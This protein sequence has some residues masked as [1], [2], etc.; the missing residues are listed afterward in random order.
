MTLAELKTILEAT[1]IPVAYR[2]F[3]ERQAPP[4]ICYYAYDTDNIG[5]DGGVYYEVS[6]VRVELYTELKNQTLE[7]TVE[8]ALT[9]FFYNKSEYYISAEKVYQIIYEIEV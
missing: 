7:K 1:G 8:A 3:T 6:N 2:F 5:A 4:F 9:G